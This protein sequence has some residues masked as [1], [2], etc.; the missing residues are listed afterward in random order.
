V[1][2]ET[3]RRNPIQQPLYDDVLYCRYLLCKDYE[4][5]RE[6]SAANLSQLPISDVMGVQNEVL[7]FQKSVSR[8]SERQTT[9]YG[10][11]FATDAE[12]VASYPQATVVR[13]EMQHE[14][15][16][17]EAI[18]C[19]TQAELAL[20]ASEDA[21]LSNLLS[22]GMPTAEL[23]RAGAFFDPC[24]ADGLQVVYRVRDLW[25]VYLAVTNVV[26]DQIVLEAL[27]CSAVRVPGVGSRPLE[28][29]RCG[30]FD[31]VSL[32]RAAVQSGST[33]LFPVAT[34]L[35]PIDEP[36]EEVWHSIRQD[37]PRG[38]VQELSH[39]DYSGAGD[40]RLIGPA[41][42]PTSIRIR[43]AS[44]AG[45]QQIHEFALGNL[46]VLNRY[47]ECGSCPHLFF[48]S[49]SKRAPAYVGELFAREPDVEQTQTL[50]VPHGAEWLVIAEL[51]PEITHIAEILIDGGVVLRDRVLRRGDQIAI[52]VSDAR[53]ILLR[54]R[55]HQRIGSATKADPWAKSAALRAFIR[56]FT[57]GS[58]L[59]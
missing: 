11:R 41:L 34:I 47:W 50:E 37:L 27:E 31:S 57:L 24:G 25:C 3:V 30:S 8:N 42:W 48:H 23:V 9:V 14:H 15:P 7:D 16:Y 6:I 59:V 29:P 55:Y 36:L 1:W 52:W 2:Y 5:I 19:P 4:A 49:S 38:S 12:F 10:P 39:A 32:P 53:H 54:G 43:R 21:L 45:V 56:S 33:V 22:E 44:T 58:E 26:A 28:T 20:L 35:S 40:A 18:W 13:D 46:Y 51:E 17:F